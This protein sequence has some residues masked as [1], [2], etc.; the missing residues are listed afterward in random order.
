[1]LQVCSFRI[2][3]AVIPIY[4]LDDTS[5]GPVCSSTWRQVNN[6]H[7]A[8]PLVLLI[9]DAASC[10]CQSRYLRC[11]GGT[12]RHLQSRSSSSFFVLPID[13]CIVISLQS[14]QNSRIGRYARRKHSLLHKCRTD[15]WR[16]CSMIMFIAAG[17]EVC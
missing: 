2:I 6:R 16:I 15:L 8:A 13:S 7:W 3:I 1:M 10:F 9:I 5:L 4:T 12:N 17:D 11:I 14:K